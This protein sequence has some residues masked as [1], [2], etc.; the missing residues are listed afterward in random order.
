[1][2][3]RFFALFRRRR[4]DRELREEIEA[5]LAM[6]EEVFRRQGMTAEAARLAARREFG[7]VTQTIETY[8]ERRGIAWIESSLADLRYAVRGLRRNPVF[9]AAA[10][11]SLALGIGANTA[12]F[13]LYHTLMLRLLPVEKPQ[14]IVSLYRTGGWGRGYASYP[15]F[16]EIRKRTDLFQDVAARTGVD[17]VRFSAGAGGLE[18]AGR[19]MVSGNYFRMLGVAPAIG[20]VF[21]DQDNRTPHAHPL[22]VLSYDFW[23]R[24]FGGA[25]GIVGRTFTVSEQPLT[26]IGVAAKGFHGVE[27]ERPADLWV[28]LMMSEAEIM[29]PGMNSVWMLGRRRPDVSAAR[30]QAALDVFYG[31]YLATLYGSTPNSAFR[32]MAMEQR[33][34]VR[35]GAAGLSLLREQFGKALS[36][37]MAAVGLVLL[38]S[39]ANVANLLLAR[40]AARRK[41][42]ALRVSLGAACGRL[43]RQDFTE[44]LLLALTGAGIGVLFALWGT[45]AML[46]FLPGSAND[47]SLA[48]PD[49]AVFGFTALL[50]VLSALL[51]GLVP[52]LRLAAVA[53]AEGLRA[54]APAGGSRTGLRKAVVMLQVA[55]SVVLVALASLFSASLAS[56]RSIDTGIR[57]ESVAAFSL[58]FP[59]SWKPAQTAVLRRRLIER[60]ESMPGVSLVSYGFPGPYLGGY[61]RTSVQIPGVAS[62]SRDPLWVERQTIGPHFFEILGSQPLAGR[63]F[64]RADFTAAPSAAI[65][66]QTFV[67]QYLR[68]EPRVLGRLLNLGNQTLTIVGVV[69]D[70]RDQGLGEKPGPTLY[71][72]LTMDAVEWEPSILVR[73]SQSPTTLAAVLRPELSRLGPD[74]AFSE[75]KTIRQQID[76][77]IFRERLLATLG[78]FFGVLALAL[79]AIGLYGVV[80]Y[81]AARRSREIGIR[82][83]LGAHRLSVVRTVVADALM[84]VAGGLV[85]GLPLAFLAARRVSGML[86]AVPPATL[87]TLAVVSFA[88]V[89]VGLIA[90]AAP[91][92]RAATLDPMRVLRIE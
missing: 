52:A 90:A 51:F 79:A 21:T 53:P 18:T 37:L 28:P 26:V 1:M 70:M 22:A 44:S 86:A 88:L 36:V 77:S 40:G 82:I 12:I 61:S 5:H 81:G 24:R 91:A 31:G 15:L 17:K 69:G 64:V 2:P 63:E 35:D 13:S 57:N 8:R 30:I 65:V 6:Q 42:I 58:D 46:G 66:N 4:L 62:V 3:G 75:P 76:E 25:P 10:I 87:T 45:H 19:E 80:A 16:L 14:Q 48:R 33:L 78:G 67:R 56:M 84:L 27:V 68:D 9:A 41:E 34:E 55:F 11:L 43:V 23:Q 85:L 83:A 7:G 38:A 29:Q 60:L 39:C 50:S 72:P 59:Q 54:A 20:R 74:I 73:S 89:A 92:R 32:R 49:A 71:L 47:T